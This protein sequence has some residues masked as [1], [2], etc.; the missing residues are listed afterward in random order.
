MLEGVGYCHNVAANKAKRNRGPAF[1]LASVKRFA[2]ARA[3]ST[4]LKCVGITLRTVRTHLP[5]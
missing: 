5:G 2:Q 3:S 1:S 4:M